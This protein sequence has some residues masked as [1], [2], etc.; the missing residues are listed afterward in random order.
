M[1]KKKKNLQKIYSLKIKKK[2]GESGYGKV[3]L[4]RK[5]MKKLQ[6]KK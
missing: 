6:L 2:I 3:Y 4:H 5:N 1:K